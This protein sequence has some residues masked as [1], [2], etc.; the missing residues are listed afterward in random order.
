MG[1]AQYGGYL[2]MFDWAT[3]WPAF[4]VVMKYLGYAGVAV[5]VIALLAIPQ[6]EYRLDKKGY[7]LITEDYEAYKEY[8]G[9]KSDDEY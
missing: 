8:K 2:G 4:T 7:Y 5:V 6:I 1:L 9:I 3:V